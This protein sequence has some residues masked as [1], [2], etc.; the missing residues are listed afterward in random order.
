MS[1]ST[2]ALRHVTLNG[3]RQAHTATVLGAL[4]E[5]PGLIASELARIVGLDPVETRRRL[6][7]LKNRKVAYP[8]HTGKGPTGRS[9]MRWWAR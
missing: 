9:E 8:Q 2:E 4:K 5:H 1:T 3:T 7:D 6:T